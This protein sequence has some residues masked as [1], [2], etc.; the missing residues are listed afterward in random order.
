MIYTGLWCGALPSDRARS[1]ACSCSAPFIDQ[2]A[3]VWAE[4]TSSAMGSVWGVCAARI[5]HLHLIRT[6]CIPDASR[7]VSVIS[8][9]LQYELINLL[10]ATRHIYQRRNVCVNAQ[11]HCRTLSVRSEKSLHIIGSGMLCMVRSVVFYN[12]FNFFQQH[13]FSLL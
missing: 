9:S 1:K 4:L 12:L 13:A 7:T 5:H 8:P 11:S 6:L 3:G 10:S 2:G